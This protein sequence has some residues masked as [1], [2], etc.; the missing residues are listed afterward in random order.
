MELRIQMSVES[1]GSE[2]ERERRK[3]GR[4]CEKA[5]RGWEERKFKK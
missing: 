1:R 5:E 3:K 4:V 2:G